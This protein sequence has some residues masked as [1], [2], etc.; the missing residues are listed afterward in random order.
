MAQCELECSKYKTV[1]L[2]RLTV[3]FSFVGECQFLFVPF[4]MIC[5]Y[6]LYC[7]SLRDIL[8]SFFSRISFFFIFCP[9]I[10]VTYYRFFNSFSLI[11]F[12]LYITACSFFVHLL[13]FFIPFWIPTI[14]SSTYF[15]ISSSLSLS[16]SLSILLPSAEFVNNTS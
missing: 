10:T 9:Y 5:Y 14:L 16:S 4:Y 7:L 1:V 8:Y 11:D 13:F 15:S 2:V 12:I 3:L 6:Y